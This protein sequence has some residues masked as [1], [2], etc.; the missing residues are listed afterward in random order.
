MH[1]KLKA[2]IQN[3]VSLLP[4]SSSYTLYYL[5]QRKFG[6]LK[7][8]DPLNGMTAGI[9]LWKQIQSQ[10][11]IP[12]GKVFFEVGTGRAPIVPLSYWLM[13]ANKTITIDVNPYL[14]KELIYEAIGYIYKNKKYI[15]NLFGHL[16]K[17]ERFDRLLKFY[18]NCNNKIYEFFEMCHIDYI[19]PGDAA[20]TS[21][22]DNVIDFH[23]S[24]NVFEHIPLKILNNILLE[25]NRI[26][27]ADGLF[28]H[29][30]DYSDH[31]S[32][33]DK[34]I[35]AINFLKYSDNL[36]SKISGNRYMYMNR[37][38]HDDF[39]NFFESVGHKFVFVGQEVDKNLINILQNDKF[40]LDKRFSSKSIDIL[41]TKNSI[42]ITKID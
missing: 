14:K 39:I 26:V 32:H 19:A 29:K 9:E 17:E 37:M 25:G 4:S 34:N 41:A 28:V 7:Q 21:L 8:F 2:I 40:C 15:I 12:T 38:R 30:I 33:D 20:K 3:V 11:Y 36:W 42:F 1:W 22:P 24:W 35:T 31:F 23:T 5:L 13:G 10:G 18:K 16:L 27:K 6:G